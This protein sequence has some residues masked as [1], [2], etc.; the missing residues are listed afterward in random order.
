M[1]VPGTC[2]LPVGTPG[3]IEDAARTEVGS[4][5][6]FIPTHL[7]CMESPSG[8][9]TYE[10]PV[11]HATGSTIA[12]VATRSGQPGRCFPH[13]RRLPAEAARHP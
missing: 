13:V 1:I 10:S 12:T 9:K 3:E 4:P 11:Q 5:K 8:F 2:I 6:N 7:G